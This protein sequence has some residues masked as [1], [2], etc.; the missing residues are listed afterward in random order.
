MDSAQ[1]SLRLKDY[2]SGLSNILYNLL[3]LSFPPLFD[4]VEMPCMGVLARMELT[5]FGFSP[6]E[7]ETQ[8]EVMQA[9][10][11]ALEEQ[12]YQMAGHG[13]SLTSPDDVAQVYY[14]Y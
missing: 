3:T 6:E 12:A 9:K 8:K 14:N 7:C 11:A 4:Q 1:R 5:G 13:F 2:I 10:L